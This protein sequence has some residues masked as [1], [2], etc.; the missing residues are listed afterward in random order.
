VPG[1]K[2]QHGGRGEGRRPPVER[3]QLRVV[4]L[5]LG[6]GVEGDPAQPLPLHRRPVGRAK[7]HWLL[8]RGGAR[9]LA[10][11]QLPHLLEPSGPI[12]RVAQEAMEGESVEPAGQ[13]AAAAQRQGG[14]EEGGDQP[15]GPRVPVQ[16]V[17]VS[18]LARLQL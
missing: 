2:H 3:R 14:E 11:K 12:G 4:C 8:L 16:P 13:R 9:R 18:G 1:R 6:P 15:V 10:L 17:R 5:L 7:L